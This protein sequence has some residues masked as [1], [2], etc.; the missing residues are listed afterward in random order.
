MGAKKIVILEIQDKSI[1][2]YCTVSGKKKCKIEALDSSCYPHQVSAQ[3]ISD[4]FKKLINKFKYDKVII[5]FTRRFFLIRF[6]SLPSQNWSEVRRMLPFQMAKGII[7][8]L[9]DVVY[10]YSL[11]VSEKGHSKMLI[12]ITQKKKIS[13]VLEFIEA[14]KVL[15]FSITNSSWGLYQWYMFRSGFFK[16]KPI[17]SNAVIDVGSNDSEFL[18]ASEDGILF[19]RSFHCLSDD[20]LL[21]GINQSLRIFEKEYGARSFNKAIFTG[22]R[23]DKVIESITWAQCVFLDQL[24]NFFFSKGVREKINDSGTSFASGLGLAVTKNYG[25]DFSPPVLKE[26]KQSLKKRKRNVQLVILVVEIMVI[27]SLFFGKYVFNRYV[28]LDFLN[29]KLQKVNIEVKEL[30]TVTEK[31]KVLDK[32]L[33]KSVSFSRVLYNVVSSVPLN[34]QLSLVDFRE[35][36]DFSIKGYAQNNEDVFAIKKLLGESGLFSSVGVKYVAKVK[37]RKGQEGFEFYMEG[38]VIQ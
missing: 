28:Y 19:S 37:G 27:L 3:D 16:Q 36:G 32:E 9:E 21:E 10:D 33:D 8:P 26:R 5:S 6:L 1:K 13:N 4:F 18:I 31:L 12:Y 38:K 15:P 23:K 29:S 11:A 22:V 17:G 25:F 2:G 20:D 14:G 7:Q 34:V 24:D 35:K 30:G